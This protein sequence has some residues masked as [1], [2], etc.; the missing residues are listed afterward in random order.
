MK[1]TTSAALLFVAASAALLQSSVLAFPLQARDGVRCQRKYTGKLYSV[2]VSSGDGGNF[3][4]PNNTVTYGNDDDRT[5][6]TDPSLVSSSPQL[7]QYD[8]CRTGDWNVDSPP[9]EYGQ[10]KPVSLAD[11]T[12]CVTAASEGGGDGETHRLYVADCG[13][14][15]GGILQWQWF[16]ANYIQEREGK[17]PFVVLTLTGNPN[18]P[19]ELPAVSQVESSVPNSIGVRADGSP[20]PISLA[21]FGVE[22]N[23]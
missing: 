15:D 10:V 17:G 4:S 1:L 3:G 11:S 21:L 23:S 8:E 9:R 2:R 6:T 5:L 16:Y 12:K 18:S 7:F 22:I 20:S 19:N 13:S 14:F